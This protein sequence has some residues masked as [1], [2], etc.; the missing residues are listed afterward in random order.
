MWPFKLEMYTT[1]TEQM[2]RNLTF[3]KCQDRV[4]T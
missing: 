4:G 3:K 1:D 2:L